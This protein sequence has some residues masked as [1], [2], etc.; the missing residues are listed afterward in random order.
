[1]P[2]IARGSDAGAL[3]SLQTKLSAVALQNEAIWYVF[4]DVLREM[5]VRFD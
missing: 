3:R 2:A 1:M 5:L 4:V